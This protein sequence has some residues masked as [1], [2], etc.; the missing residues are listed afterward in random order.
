MLLKSTELVKRLKPRM[1]SFRPEFL[2][3]LAVTV[4]V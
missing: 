3:A 4:L 2:K 1:L